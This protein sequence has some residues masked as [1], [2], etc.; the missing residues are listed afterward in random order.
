MTGIDLQEL[1]QWK[2]KNTYR[3]AVALNIPL[4]KTLFIHQVV[5]VFVKYDVYTHKVWHELVDCQ[6]PEV[7]GPQL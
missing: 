5:L 3:N 1:R 7:S 2:R 4:G 6:Q